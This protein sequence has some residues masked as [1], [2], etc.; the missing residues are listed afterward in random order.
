MT[1]PSQF[2]PYEPGTLTVPARESRYEEEQH[3]VTMSNNDNK[4]RRREWQPAPA[5]SP[6]ESRGQRSLVGYSPWDREESGTTERLHFH[7][8]QSCLGSI[9]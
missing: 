5:P 2:L 8:C 6:G 9:S 1:K 4:T 7:F 3:A